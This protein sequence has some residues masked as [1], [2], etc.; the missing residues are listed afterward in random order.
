MN[1]HTLKKINWKTSVSKLIFQS[2]INGIKKSGSISKGIEPPEG[3]KGR[4]A[5]YFLC[6][7]REAA[8]AASMSLI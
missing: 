4:H 5:A 1:N 7:L 6:C 2:P 8:A 3:R